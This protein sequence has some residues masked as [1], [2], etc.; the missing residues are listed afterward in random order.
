MALDL[1]SKYNVYEGG[2]PAPQNWN[3]LTT[4]NPEGKQRETIFIIFSQK[5][6][7]ATYNINNSADINISQR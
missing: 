1:E 5:N 7:K 6:P 2:I 3:N 4:E